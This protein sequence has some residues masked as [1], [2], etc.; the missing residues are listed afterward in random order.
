MASDDEGKEKE[1]KNIED[2]A[3]KKWNRVKDTEDEG[4]LSQGPNVSTIPLSP[5]HPQI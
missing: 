2:P 4:I 5:V 1:G 3:A